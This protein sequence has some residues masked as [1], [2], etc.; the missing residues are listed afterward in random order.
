M[1]S[2]NVEYYS[3]PDLFLFIF[4][5]VVESTLFPMELATPLG[6]GWKSNKLLLLFYNTLRIVVS[7]L[8]KASLDCF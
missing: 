7:L 6:K 4:S 5:L 8:L 1:F 3:N 2:T